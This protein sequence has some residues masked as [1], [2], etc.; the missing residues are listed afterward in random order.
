MKAKITLLLVFILLLSA[1]SACSNTPHPEYTPGSSFQPSPTASIEPTVSPTPS[2]HPD[3][4][5]P[6]PPDSS[7]DIHYDRDNSYS[8]SS[9]DVE[10]T[11]SVV[12]DTPYLM[13]TEGRGSEKIL[14]EN[15]LFIPATVFFYAPPDFEFDSTKSMDGYTIFRNHPF[16][17]DWH[18]TGAQYSQVSSHDVLTLS[19]ADEEHLIGYSIRITSFANG[20][21]GYYSEFTNNSRYSMS[22]LAY[23][24]LDIKA[25]Y[26]PKATTCSTYKINELLNFTDY[27]SYCTPQKELVYASNFSTH[28][29]IYGISVSNKEIPLFPIGIE[30]DYTHSGTFFAA[31]MQPFSNTISVKPDNYTI[32]I[33]ISSGDAEF[34]TAAESVK[35]STRCYFGFAKGSNDPFAS[36]DKVYYANYKEAEVVFCDNFDGTELDRSK[37]EKV[38]G[39][40]IY[41]SSIIY[42]EKLVYVNGNSNLIIKSEWDEANS[43]TRAGTIKTMGLAEL[44][45]GYYEIS[46]RLPSAPGTVSSFFLRSHKFSKSYL[47][48][49]AKSASSLKIDIFESRGSDDHKLNQAIHWYDESISGLAYSSSLSSRI[50]SLYDGKFHRFGLMRTA[51]EYIFYIDG[52]EFWRTSSLGVYTNDLYL[53]ISS[54]TAY[55]PRANS[56]SRLSDLI[57]DY[58]KVWKFV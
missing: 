3:Q 9:S 24:V 38:N 31:V 2:D 53:N 8:I 15:E 27:A 7:P 41:D 10:L 26:D 32:N 39:V 5:V 33:N 50:D 13:A 29:Y 43:V 36:L 30:I 42:D 56:T 4:T 49:N 19:F 22:Y 54:Y 20:M 28:D 44:G 37:W 6:V 51:T 12:D 46:A 45:L 35:E 25:T 57:V 40:D 48:N 23:S 47:L 14:Q 34:V 1:L 21:F 11:F 52:L 18:F 17:A 55:D 16:E 58:V